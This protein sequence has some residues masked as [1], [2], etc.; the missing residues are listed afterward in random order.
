MGTSSYD[1]EVG[2]LYNVQ[3]SNQTFSGIVQSVTKDTISFKDPADNQLKAIS[4]KDITDAN[5]VSLGA[6]VVDGLVGI[7]TGGNQPNIPIPPGAGSPKETNG[8]VPG[9]KYHRLGCGCG[10]CG[11]GGCWIG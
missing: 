2:K 7:G 1:F 8:G 3:T 9:R 10:K 5:K 11:D 4:R 6:K